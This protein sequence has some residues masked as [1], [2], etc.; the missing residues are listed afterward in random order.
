MWNT[1]RVCDPGWDALNRAA[2]REQ[3]PARRAQM[4]RDLQ[5]GLERTGAFVFLY[6]GLNA[7]GDAPARARRLD[8]RRPL[9]PAARHHRGDRGMTAARRHSNPVREENRHGHRR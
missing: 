6:N 2:M 8:P 4:Y 1:E 5:D 9:G 7:W 3:D